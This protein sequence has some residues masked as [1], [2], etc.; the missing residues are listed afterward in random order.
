MDKTRR[1]CEGKITVNLKRLGNEGVNGIHPGRD[2]ERRLAAANIL[3]K[4]GVP[5]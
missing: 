2:I 1:E 3:T 4:F 5:H